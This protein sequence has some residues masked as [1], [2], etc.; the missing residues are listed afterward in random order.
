MSIA[1]T[2]PFV[3]HCHCG[4]FML[5]TRSG[6]PHR[7]SFALVGSSS[8]SWLPSHL[9]TKKERSIMFGWAFVVDFVSSS[10]RT[11]GPHGAYVQM[12][13]RNRIDPRQAK[14]ERLTMRTQRRGG[15][16]SS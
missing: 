13:G 16:P 5:G 10:A 11:E 6:W 1:Q 4:A 3:S 15:T 8:T 7:L 9:R 14:I 12:G 2:D